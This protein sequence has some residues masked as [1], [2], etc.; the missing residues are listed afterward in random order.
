MNILSTRVNNSELIHA[1]N[2]LKSAGIIKR[3]ND[4]AERLG[5]TRSM[6]S[7]YLNNKRQV[8]D[9]FMIKFKAEF[10]SEKNH[11]YFLNLIFSLNCKPISGS[12][13]LFTPPF[14]PIMCLSDIIASKATPPL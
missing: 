12:I 2:R 8:S 10:Q 5:Y 9:V 13:K 11:L 1:V 6:V 7:E 3:D 14:N 4:I